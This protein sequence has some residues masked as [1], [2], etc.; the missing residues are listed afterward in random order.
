MVLGP[1]NSMTGQD[2]REVFLEEGT[3]KPLKEE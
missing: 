1:I 2:I 3:S